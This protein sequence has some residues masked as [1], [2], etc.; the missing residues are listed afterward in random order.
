M[1][2]MPTPKERCYSSDAAYSVSRNLRA[3]YRAGQLKYHN[4]AKRAG[5]SL[6][7][8]KEVFQSEKGLLLTKKG[9]Y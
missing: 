4:P 2:T 6:Y 1:D 8:T 5:A 3:E 9:S 7:F